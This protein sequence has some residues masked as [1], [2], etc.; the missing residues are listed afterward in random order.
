[1]AAST[2]AAA[3]TILDNPEPSTHGPLPKISNAQSASAVR[4]IAAFHT[5][6]VARPVAAAR[7]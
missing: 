6:D 5:D 2:N 3:A 7:W 4:G 1:M